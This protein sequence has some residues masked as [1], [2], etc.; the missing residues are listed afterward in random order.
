M[1]TAFLPLFSLIHKKH[2]ERSYSPLSSEN[3][4]KYKARYPVPIFHLNPRI[5]QLIMYVGN[6]KYVQQPVH[7]QFVYA[8]MSYDSFYRIVRR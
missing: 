4:Q 3:P 6:A 7:N 2:Q 5:Y 1:K 8:L